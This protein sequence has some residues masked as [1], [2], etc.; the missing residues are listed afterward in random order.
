MV[1]WTEDQM[2]D[3]MALLAVAL[4]RLGGHLEVTADEL[5]ASKAKYGVP[6]PLMIARMPDDR[7]VGHLS[8]LEAMVD[9]QWP[10]MAECL[11]L[12]VV[13]AR[14][15]A[16]AVQQ[17]LIAQRAV[18]QFHQAVAEAHRAKSRDGMN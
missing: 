12:D 10:I 17:Q 2:Q 3:T 16:T 11:S 15:A 5:A 8:A 14:A 18:H 4:E 9:E 6:A 1:D 7:L 13:Q